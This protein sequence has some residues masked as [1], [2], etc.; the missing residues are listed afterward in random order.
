MTSEAEDEFGKLKS[1]LE[2]LM[3]IT[4]TYA[5]SPQDTYTHDLHQRLDNLAMYVLCS[6][7]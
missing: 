3:N 5:K 6:L 2:A 4:D 7:I 1:K